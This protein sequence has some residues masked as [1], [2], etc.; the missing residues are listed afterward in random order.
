MQKSTQRLAAGLVLAAAGLAILPAQM[1]N[2]APKP[3]EFNAQTMWHK[4]NGSPYGAGL[5]TRKTVL[6]PAALEETTAPRT[7][8]ALITVAGPQEPLTTHTTWTREIRFR[9]PRLL[10]NGMSYLIP[11]PYRRHGIFLLPLNH[12]IVWAPSSSGPITAAGYT[13]IF[14]TPY[15]ARGGSLAVHAHTIASLP[16]AWRGFNGPTAA[17]A[18]TGWLPAHAIA[19]ARVGHLTGEYAVFAGNTKIRNTALTASPSLWPALLDRRLARPAYT[20]RPHNAAAI[21]SLTRT[22]GGMVLQAAFRPVGRPGANAGLT[23]ASYYWSETTYQW[24]PIAQDYTVQTVPSW[25]S[26]GSDG[27]YGEESL[28]YQKGLAV[29]QT[30]FS[31]ATLSLHAIWLGQWFTGAAVVAGNA[32]LT[33]LPHAQSVGSKPPKSWTIYTP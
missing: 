5:T 31:P 18:W 23:S 11:G 22:N 27:V 8:G 2:A 3:P 6:S 33:V 24:T 14:Y 7:G 28:P 9:G 30:A 10:I 17:T 26:V 15:R 21:A 13:P 16:H 19:P 25:T 20:G 32:W 1:V 12:G 4:P 29:V